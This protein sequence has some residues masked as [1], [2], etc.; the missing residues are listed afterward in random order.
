MSDTL[1]K[2]GNMD[3]E[4]RRQCEDTQGENH[5]MTGPSH[6]QAKEH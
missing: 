2:G 1:I 4:G 3:T 5:P 6:P